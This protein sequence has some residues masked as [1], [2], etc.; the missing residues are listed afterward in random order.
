[1]LGRRRIAPVVALL[2]GAPLLAAC[3]PP[4][5]PPVFTVDST[6]T[7]A[8]VDPGDGTCDDGDGNCTLP[9]AIEEANAL[10][11]AEIVLPSDLTYPAIEDEITG[12]V[13]LR[14]VLSELLPGAELY[15]TVL[16]VAADAT[17]AIS[18]VSL[19]GGS[20]VVFGGLL[21]DRFV[22]DTLHV[23]AG[24]AAVVRNAVA[25]GASAD[26]VV[27]NEGTLRLE[28]STLISVDD[29][30]LVDTV[31]G[32][33]TLLRSNLLHAETAPVC[34]GLAPASE[35]YNLT[36]DASCSLTAAGDLQ[37]VDAGH[38]YPDPGA[39]HRDAV[40]FGEAG[41]GTEVPHDVLGNPRPASGDP[42][43]AC[44]IGAWEATVS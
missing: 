39:P 42:T 32:G 19:A 18:G 14:G 21:A 36:S 2:V 35:G 15:D 11:A 4:A 22:V 20:V 44:D 41:C 7:T 17:L 3:D 10:G 8:D 26:P 33:S 24:G 31:A 37:S 1:M 43:S 16:V 30:A 23:R 9:A 5:P 38:H 27:R 34:T 6:A 40:P 25:L 28:S 13:T 29:G 12:A